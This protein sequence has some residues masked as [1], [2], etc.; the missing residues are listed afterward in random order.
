[1]L[2]KY[3]ELLERTLGELEAARNMST[4]ADSILFLKELLMASNMHVEMLLK[5]KQLNKDAKES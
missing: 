2:E 5:R 3:D 1:M 4:K